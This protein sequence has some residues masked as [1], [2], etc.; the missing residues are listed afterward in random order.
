MD[1]VYLCAAGTS[2]Q[3]SSNQVDQSK[4]QMLATH[5][6]SERPRLTVEAQT[7]NVSEIGLGEHAH[8]QHHE[9]LLQPL[10]AKRED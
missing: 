7:L 9:T 6:M 8:A 3:C 4:G 10:V 2:E 5:D 1:V